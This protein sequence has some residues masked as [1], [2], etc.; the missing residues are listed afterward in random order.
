[1][2][3]FLG[4]KINMKYIYLIILSVFVSILVNLNMDSIR[5]FGARTVVPIWSETYLQTE[6]SRG[7]FAD[8]TTT[9]IAVANPFTSTSTVDLFILD[10]TGVATATAAFDCGTSTTAT[11]ATTADGLIDNITVAT[12]TKVYLAAGGVES[13]TNS[14]SVIKVAKNNY[15]V[16]L[17]TTGYAAAFTQA[18]NTFD[19][20]YLIRW[21]LLK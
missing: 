17:A 1:M 13:G 20:K 15:I 9:F 12:S 4:T 2:L 21:N 14:K 16:C 18:T 7:S 5:S 6:I 3:A 10:Q 19:G 8:A 11:G